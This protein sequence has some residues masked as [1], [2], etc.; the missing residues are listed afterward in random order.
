MKHSF[1]LPHDPLTPLN[2]S[3]RPTPRTIRLLRTELYANVC[4]VRSTLGGGNHGH[5]G[6]LMPNDE[7][8]LISNGGTPYIAP[9]D[10]PQVPVFAG[11]AAVVAIMQENYHQDVRKYEEYQDLSNHIKAMMLQAIPK[12]YTGAP[13]P[14]ST[15]I[16]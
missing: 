1:H 10:P 15:W 9:A 6:M 14:C 12:A 4:S 13:C 16:C 3:T 2:M 8:V 5:L 7:Y 11:A